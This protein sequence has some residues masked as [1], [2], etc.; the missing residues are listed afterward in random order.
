MIV[1]HHFYEIITT[2]VLKVA[3]LIVNV[4]Y[5]S[6]TKDDSLDMIPFLMF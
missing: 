4:F 2:V 5:I 3:Y 6:K 1:L